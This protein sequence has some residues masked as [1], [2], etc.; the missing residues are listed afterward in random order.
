VHAAPK[1]LPANRF[2]R[3]RVAIAEIEV[4]LKPALDHI[5]I[6]RRRDRKNRSSNDRK[7]VLHK[8]LPRA[9]D[10][11]VYPVEGRLQGCKPMERNH[12]V[13]VLDDKT[14]STVVS[15]ILP[16]ITISTD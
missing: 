15:D 13:S 14:R 16:L 6:G 7:P 5:R 9:D 1:R 12:I 4:Q 10:S 11:A 2:A 8:Y 3:R